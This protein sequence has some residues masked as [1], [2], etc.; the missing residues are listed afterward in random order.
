MK[1]IVIIC[2]T[3]RDHREID[4][5]STD[6][7]YRHNYIFYGKNPRENLSAFDPHGFIN[8]FQDDPSRTN[9]SVA[10]SNNQLIMR[11]DKAVYCIGQ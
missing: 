9:A 4:K 8:K 10:V 3:I 6:E 5:I 2:P 11:T 7:K 1:N